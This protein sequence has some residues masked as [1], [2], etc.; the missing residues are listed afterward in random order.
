M[1]FEQLPKTNEKE[2]R[3]EEMRSHLA[4]RLIKI[5][6]DLEKEHNYKFDPW[7]VD[8]VLVEVI[9]RHQ[10]D[11]MRNQFKERKTKKDGS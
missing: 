6:Q 11:Y 9:R 1:S 4:L 8:A 5:Q 2:Q 10:H 7:E 3:S